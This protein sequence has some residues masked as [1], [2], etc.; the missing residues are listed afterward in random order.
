MKIKFIDWCTENKTGLTVAC[1][2][3]GLAGT[4]GIGYVLGKR[5]S[6][7]DTFTKGTAA[8]MKLMAAFYERNPE[9]T[10]DIIKSWDPIKFAEGSEEALDDMMRGMA[11]A[12]GVTVEHI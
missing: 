7:V 6:D 9:L 4:A 2:V 3:A 5:A 1:V 8:G 11:E 10:K 12:S